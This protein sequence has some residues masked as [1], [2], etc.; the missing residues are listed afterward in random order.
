MNDF[1][2]RHTIALTP[3]SP[4]HI[5]CDE[6]FE[7][8][9][10]VIDADDKLLYG[11]DPSRAALPEALVQKLTQLGEKG[12]WLSI[13]AF[14]RDN[15]QLFKPLAHVL[16]PV[17]NGI[18]ADYRKHIGKI[19]NVEVDGRQVINRLSI[20]RHTHSRD[21]PY[22]PGS[23]LKGALRT[24]LMDRLNAGQAVTDK[25]EKKESTKLARRLLGGDFA[26]SPLRLL[27]VGDLTPASDLDRSV[28]YAVNRYKHP[29]FDEE[30]GQQKAPRGVVAR[31]ECIQSGQYRALTGEI[32]IHDLGENGIQSGNVPSRSLRPDIAQLA[33]DSNAYHLPRLRAE[34][35]DMDRTGLVH[36]TWKQSVESLLNG[37]LKARLDEGHAMLIRVGR[38]GGAESKTLTEAASIKIM[39]KRV[40]GKQ[41]YDFRSHTTTYWLAAQT[42]EDQKHLIPFGWAILEIDPTDDLPELKAWC[43]SEAKNRPDMKAIYAALAKEKA[44]AKAEAARIKAERDAALEAARKAEEAAAQA[45]ADRDK[46]RA[47]LSEAGRVVETFCEECEKTF[48]STGGRKDKSYGRNYNRARV[49]AENARTGEGWRAADKQAAAKAI[50]H[51]LPRL[52]TLEVKDVRK[53]LKLA[54][55]EGGQA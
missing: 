45:A 38:Y 27:K 51:W 8:T 43:E 54:E 2:S 33:K 5:G 24:A 41:Q 44:A 16:M 40:D 30:S 37:A 1:L 17:A 42:A 22:I 11:F 14:F 20:E 19:S 4:I 25:D 28:L 47:T 39:G 34:L 10:Y 15:Q 32:A 23:S 9:N 50:E 35:A 7:P 3:L 52:E 48:Q 6:D 31:K 49:L 29:K 13:Q 18:A 21:T 26:T 55:L 46:R 53:K 12:D 36:P